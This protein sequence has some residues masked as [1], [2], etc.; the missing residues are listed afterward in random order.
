M[1]VF[2]LIAVFVFYLLISSSCRNNSR[3]FEN[4]LPDAQI[5]RVPYDTVKDNI[6]SFISGKYHVNSNCLN[7]FDSLSSWKQ[8]S[9]RMDS[10]FSYLDTS[11]LIKMSV[12]AETEITYRHDTSVLFYPFGGPD[13]LNANAFYPNVSRYILI[14]LEPVGKLPDICNMTPSE[15]NEYLDDIWISLNDIF[16][17]SYFITGHMIDDLQKEEVGGVTPVISIF[18]KRKGYKI[19]SVDYIG[20]DINGN[21]QYS[22]SLKNKKSFAS[23]VKI[24]FVHDTS[25]II[26]TL[27]YFRANLSDEGLKKNEPLINYLYSLPVC[28]TYLKAASYLMH[29]KEFSQIRSLIL[30]KSKSILQDDSGIAYKFFD[31]EHWDIKL[32]G[33]YQR[34]GKEFSWINE[35]DLA[36]AYKKMPVKQVPFTLGYNWRTRAINLL[37]AVK[38]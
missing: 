10:G 30:D 4:K 38:K 12:W 24:D 2:R 29:S 35:T 1:P 13:F 27:F 19:V 22:D 9:F 26:Q 3:L 7:K 11:R 33:K 18:I 34:P 21:W 28:N 5:Y 6:I 17:R 37:Y 14:G 16:R 32:Y 15:V 31:K 23:G 36:E 20:I 25:N 8:F